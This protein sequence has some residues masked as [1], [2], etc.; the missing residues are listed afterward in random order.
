MRILHVSISTFIL[1]IL[2]DTLILEYVSHSDFTTRL[3]TLKLR[4]LSHERNSL[5]AGWVVDQIK[6]S[7]CVLHLT[8][9]FFCLTKSFIPFLFY[10]LLFIFFLLKSAKMRFQVAMLTIPTIKQNP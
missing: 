9:F 10:M 8:V 4:S 2:I 1:Y 5:R 3:N 6:N 7:F